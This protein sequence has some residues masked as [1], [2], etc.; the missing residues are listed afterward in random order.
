ML[1][2]AP[3][4]PSLPLPDLAALGAL[5]VLI[6]HRVEPAGWRRLGRGL[7][8]LKWLLFSIAVLYLGFTPGTPLSPWTPGLSWEGLHEGGRRV[9]VIGVLLTLV[10]TLMAS[11]PL[12]ELSAALGQALAPLRTLGVPVDRFIRRLA[13]S[14]AALDGVEAEVRRLREAGHRGLDLLAAWVRAIEARPPE[15]AAEPATVPWPR[16]W[17]W[18]ALAALLTLTVL[19]PR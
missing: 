3:A 7:A 2:L 4:L 16:A 15:V 5:L 13:L 8:R 11:T 9:L 1:I 18:G 17:E 6:H 12:P 14:F 10:Y 19:W